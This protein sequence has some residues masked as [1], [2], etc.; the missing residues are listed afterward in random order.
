MNSVFFTDRNLGKQFP[1]II[2][3]AGITVERH[4]DHFSHDLP[5]AEWLRVVGERGW[6]AITHD[7]KIR[8]KPNE[9]AAV[10]LYR[11]SLLVVIGKAPF[12]ELAHTF[13]AT[14]PKVSEFLSNH[15]PPFI[16][17]IYRPNP[18]ELARGARAGR[19]EL[20]HPKAP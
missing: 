5:D 20:W 16:A 1:S 8:Y 15:S 3:A 9:L 17:K 18:S 4:Q 14:L 6:V 10:V 11:V 7:Q 13:V 2:S 12:P 19:V